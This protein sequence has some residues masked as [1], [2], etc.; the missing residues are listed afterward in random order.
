MCSVSCAAS[1]GDRVIPDH[2]GCNS[3][4]S[5][6]CLSLEQTMRLLLVVVPKN[7]QGQKS[8]V[9]YSCLFV[10]RP[11]SSSI[12]RAALGYRREKS[13]RPRSFSVHRSIARRVE[14]FMAGRRMKL[15]RRRRWGIVV[16][17]GGAG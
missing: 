11:V 4:G 10:P 12:A 9:W 16:S 13:R 3:S 17:S 15:R 8:R 2:K 7:F 1:S 14:S 5:A 6:A